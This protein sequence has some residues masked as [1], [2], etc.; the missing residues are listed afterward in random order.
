M[1]RRTSWKY[2]CVANVGMKI[3]ISLRLRFCSKADLVPHCDCVAVRFRLHSNSVHC[4]IVSDLTD[5][6]QVLDHNRCLGV[7]IQPSKA[8]LGRIP[9]KSTTEATAEPSGIG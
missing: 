2:L 1:T 6:S 8:G 9:P 7:F 3:G 4:V 5:A